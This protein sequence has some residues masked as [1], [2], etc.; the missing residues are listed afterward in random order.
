MISRVFR[1]VSIWLSNIGPVPDCIG[2]LE[3]V[4]ARTIHLKTIHQQA[5][6]PLTKA[7]PALKFSPESDVCQNFPR[8]FCLYSSILESRLRLSN[9]M[10][11]PLYP[12]SKQIV[13]DFK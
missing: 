9:L 2:T 8:L 13:N 11:I 10:N 7:L 6:P 4:R 1:H 5:L 12:N 3:G